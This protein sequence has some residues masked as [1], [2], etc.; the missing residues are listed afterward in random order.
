MKHPENLL[1]ELK[2]YYIGI[3]S[4]RQ[5]YKQNL[6][7]CLKLIGEQLKSI[8]VDYIPFQIGKIDQVLDESAAVKQ[9]E[10]GNKYKRIL[11]EFR[12]INRFC[13]FFS[14]YT[15][16]LS[17]DY[18]QNTFSILNDL[19]WNAEEQYHF[20]VL[21]Q[22]D[23]NYHYLYKTSSQKNYRIFSNWVSF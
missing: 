23:E 22:I 11:N 8:A 9:R 6:D 13:L 7:T 17:V 1:E 20:D 14:S 19:D 15:V 16:Q 12:N 3:K 21:L 2:S 18:L 4:N 5:L 10:A